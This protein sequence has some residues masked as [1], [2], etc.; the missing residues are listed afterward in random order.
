MS[1]HTIIP[2]QYT[3]TLPYS[4]ISPYFPHHHPLCCS[5]ST[6]SVRMYTPCRPST[7]LHSAQLTTWTTTLLQTTETLPQYPVCDSLESHIHSQYKPPAEEEG[8]TSNGH[9]SCNIRPMTLIQVCIDSSGHAVHS[10]ITDKGIRHSLQPTIDPQL[11]L[12]QPTTL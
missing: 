6:T 1:H 2:H 7:H 11:H 10:H 4:T 9:I 5:Q 8:S 3:N 12:N